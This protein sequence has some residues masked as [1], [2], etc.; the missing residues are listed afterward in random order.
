LQYSGKLQKTASGINILTLAA[1]LVKLLILRW[2]SA[3]CPG[4]ASVLR[5]KF[6]ANPDLLFPRR[7]F[8]SRSV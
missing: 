4:G 1:E 7:A 5:L 6:A 3:L 8:A 2:N